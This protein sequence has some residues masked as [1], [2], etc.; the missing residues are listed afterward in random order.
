MNSAG[1]SP[2]KELS[3]SLHTRDR[4]LTYNPLDDIV[5]G[6]INASHSNKKEVLSYHFVCR[7]SAGKAVISDIHT[8]KDDYNIRAVSSIK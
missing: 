6:F 2:L 3:L 5:Y 1:T 8:S 7:F 4:N